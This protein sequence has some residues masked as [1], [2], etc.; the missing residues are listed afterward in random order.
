MQLQQRRI[1][2]LG[3]GGTGLS[4]L[5]GL[6]LA[7][8]AR[9][10]GCDVA[11]TAITDRLEAMGARITLDGQSPAHVE[12]E[13]VL[14]YTTRLSAAGRA[15][16]AAARDAGLEVLDRPHLLAGLVGAAD[17]IGVAGTHGKTT[18]TAMVAH[19]LEGVG[20]HPSALIGDG[21]SSRVGD[22]GLLVAELDESDR[23]LP[24]H[25]PGAAIVT[26]VGFD[27]GDYYRDL[28]DVRDVF[29]DFLS[30]LPA[31]GVAVLCADDPW[32][33]A[34]PVPGRRVTYGFA[35]DATYRLDEGG[36]IWRG[37]DRLAELRLRR[38]GVVSR[39]DATAAL[40]VAVERGVDPEAAA[41][42]LDDFPGAHRRLERLGS[43]HGADLYDDY[44]H[45]PPQ[46]EP[47]VQALRELP[48]QRVLLV[49]QPHRF[50]RFG[51]IED[52][53]ET[54]LRAA[55]RTLLAEIYGAGELN[56]EGLSARALARR[57][58]V[59][60]AVDAGEVRD[61]LEREVRAGDLVLLMGAGNIATT[62]K[63]ELGRDLAYS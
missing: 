28:D 51:D 12:G 62:V 46:I 23:S 37:G 42:A 14:C 50:S 30:G 16:V 3:I 61:W 10:S 24:L 19:L 7:R 17:T 26:G 27:H 52:A 55:D 58:G 15:E 57:S 5:A 9:V 11:R 38:P 21:A 32:L 54:E 25:H 47:T 8:G 63:E 59:D 35:V 43:W 4:A 20:A 60:F 41:R 39:L 2:L 49:F 22:P 40:A 33:V 44:G 53:L 6:L 18:T 36:V 13:D 56:P 31:A 1:H 29:R 45:L 48:H 34:Q